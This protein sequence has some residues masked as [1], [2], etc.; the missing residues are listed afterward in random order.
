MPEDPANKSE[1]EILVVG[2]LRNFLGNAK[3][4]DHS[5]SVWAGIFQLRAR[6]LGL[7]GLLEKYIESHERTPEEPAY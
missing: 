5:S 1:L 2:A 4:N 6:L 7:S 3:R